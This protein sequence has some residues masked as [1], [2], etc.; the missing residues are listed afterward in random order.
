MAR[1]T[2][3]GLAWLL[4]AAVAAQVFVAGLAI[5]VDPSW[6]GTHRTQ[7]IRVV[8][9]AALLLPVLSFPARLPTSLRW[10]SAAP[11]VL[12]AVQYATIEAGVPVLAAIHPVSA[13][14]FFWVAATLGRLAWTAPDDRGGSR[15]VAVPP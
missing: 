14:L 15:T 13:V 6:W 1:V 10:F 11:L 4:A 5:F 7:I 2:F 9:V 3:V 12:V 8:E